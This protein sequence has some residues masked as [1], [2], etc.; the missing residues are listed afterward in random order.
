LSIVG[1]VRSGG[2]IAVFGRRISTITVDRAAAITTLGILSLFSIILALLLTQ[3]IPMTA[4]VFEAVSALATVG[5]SIGATA[6]LDSVGKL[7]VAVA[8]FAGRVGPL[9]VFALLAARESSG[10]VRHPVEPIDVG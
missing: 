3:P 1:A 4:A 8:M 6:Q 2:E 5:L 7:I 9:S 10:S